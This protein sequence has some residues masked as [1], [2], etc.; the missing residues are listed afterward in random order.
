[1]IISKK[2]TSRI[3]NPNPVHHF[4]ICI[5]L[6]TPSIFF[7]FQDHHDGYTLQTSRFF[8]DAIHGEMEYPFSQYGPLWSAFLGFVGWLAPDSLQLVGIRFFSVLAVAISLFISARIY[9][10]ISLKRLPLSLTVLVVVTWYFFGPYYGWPS[11]F[12][13]PFIAWLSLAICQKIVDAKKYRYSPFIIGVCIGLVQLARV[14]IGLLLLLSL[15]FLFIFFFDR[16]S[17]VFLLLGYTSTLLIVALILSQYGFLSDAIYDQYYFGLRFHISSDRGAGRLPIWTLLIALLTILVIRLLR[18]YW[19]RILIGITSVVVLLIF[20]IEN[21]ISSEI[22]NFFHWRVVQRSYV[23]LIIGISI[24]LAF[25]VVKSCWS[26]QNRV[27]LKNSPRNLMN[28]SLSLIALCSV[29][30][31]YPL[32]ASHHAWYSLIPLLLA[33][34]LNYQSEIVP[35]KVKIVRIFQLSLYLSVFLFNISWYANVAISH[36]RAP[37]NQIVYVDKV[38]KG[39]MIKWQTFANKYIPVNSTI[40]SLCRDALIFVVREDLK[41]ASRNYLWW[42]RFETFPDYVKSLQVSSDFIL[43]CENNESAIAKNIK[44]QNYT[45]IGTF[46]LGPLLTLY[47]N[48]KAS[49]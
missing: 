4:L 26:K 14:Q 33:F 2:I 40:H 39:L 9:N 15:I 37:I 3:T 5:L 17:L 46:Q 42:D 7:R 22:L 23:G 49:N 19:I 41:P 28:L 1:M 32:F 45:K 47:S 27:Q 6:L 18:N 44:L 34:S 11:I 10:F 20:S 43:A 38:E 16:I 8:V 29:S 24:Y 30:Q 35:S 21:T 31:L 36:E 12:V 25:N 13:L 48:E